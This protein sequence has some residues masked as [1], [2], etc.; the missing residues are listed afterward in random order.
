MCVFVSNYLNA[1]IGSAMDI[2]KKLKIKPE[3]AYRA[4]EPLI[5]KT[6]ENIKNSGIEKSL[7]GPIERGD[8]NTIKTHHSVLNNKIP[9]LLPLYRVLGLKTLT[10][11]KTKIAT[12]SPR[13]YSYEKND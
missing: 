9:E 5:Y 1:L 11:V 6:L 8:I 4:L 3:T 7:S 13:I 12:D 10:L 2:A